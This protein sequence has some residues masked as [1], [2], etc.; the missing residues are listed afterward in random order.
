M[1][2]ANMGTHVV[3]LAVLSAAV[4]A[5]ATQAVAEVLWADDFTRGGYPTDTAN[6]ET[7]AGYI[8]GSLLDGTNRDFYSWYGGT[9]T[10]TANTVNAQPVL[11]T[12]GTAKLITSKAIPNFASGISVDFDADPWVAGN[13]TNTGW[14]AMNLFRD[15]ADTDPIVNNATTPF[16]ILF[17]ET[18]RFQPYERG[19][20]KA[21]NAAGNLDPIWT[22]TPLNAWHHFRLEARLN[23]SN[24]AVVNIFVDHNPLPVYSYT[25]TSVN[26]V[27]GNAVFETRGAANHYVDNYVIG[28]LGARADWNV[29]S[30]SNTNTAGNWAG[31]IPTGVDAVA[32]FGSKITAARTVTVN[33][34][35][36]LGR[37]TFDNASAYTLNGT[38]AN[39]ITLQT[40]T[41][42]MPSGGTV[43][44]ADAG[45]GAVSGTGHTVNAPLVLNSDLAVSANT[46]AALTVTGQISGPG[47][48]TKTGLG[49]VTLVGANTFTGPT[50]LLD[51]TLG[52]SQP[53]SLGNNT[54]PISMSGGSTLRTDA[55]M[56]LTRD[57]ALGGGA[58]RNPDVLVPSTTTT[59][60]IALTPAGVVNTNG[61]VVTLS[62]VI[63][64]SITSGAN[65]SG[66][67]KTGAGT[68]TLTGANTYAGPT[69]VTGGTLAFSAAAN[70]GNGST[71]NNLA[72][73]NGST[74][75]TDAALTLARTIALGTGGGGINTNGNAATASGVISGANPFTKSGAGT[76]T[77]TAANTYTGATTVAGGT[78]K[79]G[80]ANGIADASVVAVSAGATFD[81]NGQTE[82]I[83]G[84]GAGSGTVALNGGTLTLNAAA[85]S[86][87]NA[88]VTGPGTL[89]K[90]GAAKATVGSL[91]GPAVT[92]SAGTLALAA[93]KTTN[94]VAG[95][96]LT[97]TSS[98]DLA[99][100]TL[101]VNAAG[102]EPA[103]FTK[104]AAAFHGGAWD[105]PGLTTSLAGAPSNYTT[106]IGYASTASATTLKYTWIGDADLNGIVNGADVALF[107]LDGTDWNHGDFNYDHVVNADDYT[108]LLRGLAIGDSDIALV[109][110]P[111]AVAGALIAAAT[112]LTRRS[113]RRPN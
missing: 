54:T 29:D 78:L 28:T 55:D 14:V 111:S 8:G 3:R 49:T 74:L 9:G 38:A 57:I 86:S 7:Q 97:G 100:N 79:L 11:T 104:V 67:A 96:T 93:T 81:V 110:E 6:F 15:E 80:A 88:A 60:D 107:T 33:A 52:I 85:A 61:K 5:P 106:A 23:A 68:L 89:V 69:T 12:N 112:L 63:S 4:L 91:Q 59:G 35:I 47:G 25:A 42:T 84:L 50:S 39:P 32:N 20:L 26:T 44:V 18:G 77:L 43:S 82:T 90:Q 17:R 94:A 65:A 36:T 105:Q 76:L 103:L 73:S 92:A 40:T 102:A 53:Q 2:R 37:I 72:L 70:L 75:R 21:G 95:L 58:T 71:T 83:G 101:V 1:M 22:S 113:R 34:P 64:G 56:T 16:G 108:L 24:Q 45:I 19:V 51:G 62:G 10:H 27:G 66:F 109:P 87:G 99:N 13:T 46:G 98:F 31:G 48:L 30:S 41:Y